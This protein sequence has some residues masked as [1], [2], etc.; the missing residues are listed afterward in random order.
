MFWVC[1]GCSLPCFADKPKQVMPGSYYYQLDF[2]TIPLHRL[3]CSFLD[4]YY[5]TPITALPPT[6]HS[7]PKNKDR[8]IKGGKNSQH[9]TYVMP[10]FG[11]SGWWWWR[12]GDA[13]L[14]QS[15]CTHCLVSTSSSRMLIIFSDEA[16]SRPPPVITDRPQ[17]TTV[18]LTEDVE[19]ECKAS[20]NPSP[21]IRWSHGGR[22]VLADSR[23]SINRG[24]LRIT[25][26]FEYVRMRNYFHKTVYYRD[27]G[28]ESFWFWVNALCQN[29]C[30]IGVEPHSLCVVE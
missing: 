1:C 5:I 22:P 28:L 9:G 13:T 7:K 25:G 20:G 6:S 17:N 24:S 27:K 30:R 15:F 3:S 4:S 23:I 14:Q 18:P 8:I 29:R 2:V 12:G 11:D 10:S 21:T 16:D 26:R 19:L